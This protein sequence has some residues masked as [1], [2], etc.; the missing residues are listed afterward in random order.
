MAAILDPPLQAPRSP[1]RPRPFDFA[2]EISH[3][4]GWLTRAEGTSL[5]AAA[6]RVSHRLA[7]VEI[8][9]FKGRST[10]CL[11]LGARAGL[12]AWVFAV[13]PHRGNREHQRQFGPI[14][15]FA[16]F[17]RNLDAAG[18]AENVAGIRDGSSNVA[19][20]FKRSVGLLFVDGDH[21]LG[22]VLADLRQW[23]PLVADG[24]LIAVHDAWQIPGPHLATLRELLWS[25][26]IRNPRLVDTIT[27]FEKTAANTAADRWRNRAFCLWRLAWGLKGFIRLKLAGTCIEHTPALSLADDGSEGLMQHR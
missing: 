27:C 25:R 24:G 5:H 20:R 9:S 23:M 8:G 7:I 15:T 26:S 13:D 3:V 6:R 21:R 18:V 10:I 12:G 1:H 22:A 11:A 19:A 17:T 16:D 2:S 4:P 14:D